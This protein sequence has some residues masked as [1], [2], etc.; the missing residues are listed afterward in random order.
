MARYSGRRVFRASPGALFGLA[1][2][3]VLFASGAAYMFLQGGSPLTAWGLGAMTVLAL[4]GLLDWLVTRV[5]LRE[6]AVLVRTLWSR[7]R[8]PREEVAGVEEAKGV[9]PALKLA[10][11]GWAKIPEVIGGGFGNSVRAWLKGG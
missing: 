2:V 10:G 5:E 6:D 3:A 8:Y 4:V 7:R 9:A 11:G 1:L